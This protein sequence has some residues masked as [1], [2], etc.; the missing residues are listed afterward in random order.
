MASSAATLSL[1]AHDRDSWRSLVSH[2]VVSADME[3]PH[4]R[5]F[6]GRIRSS[7]AFDLGVF[8]MACQRHGAHRSAKHISDREPEIVLTMTKRGHL[9]LQ[10]NGRETRI[11]PGNFSLYTSYDSTRISSSDD[12]QAVAAK[13]P[14]SRCRA[15]QE[16][17]RELS[18]Q[19]F[20]AEEGLAL[21]VWKMT[22]HLEASGSLGA[23]MA[24]S[25][26]SHHIIGLME[27]MLHQQLGAPHPPDNPVESML[28]QCYRY[29]ESHLQDPHLSPQ[30]VAEACFIST[31]YLHMIFQHS[32]TTVAAHIRDRRLERAHHDLVDPQLHA[33][34]V[35]TIARRW[36]F[37]SASHFGQLFKKAYG[38]PPAQYR[39][40]AFGC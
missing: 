12:Y 15:N 26:A 1:R 36:G 32:G 20:S 35:D 5:K 34:G 11:R 23:T 9:N 29:I 3:L 17:F 19:S 33:L 14:L 7:S 40:E 38:L 8:S 10:Q 18:A 2:V 16:Q 28:N 25:Q 27:Q 30:R 22:D 39:K 31:R 6:D 4:G 37:A 24:T 21:A 13:I